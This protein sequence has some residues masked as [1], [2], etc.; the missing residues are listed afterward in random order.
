[1][2]NKFMQL[3]LVQAKTAKANNE[4]PVGAV[5]V[6]N[7]KVIANGYN[8]VETK[9]NSILHAEVIAI[10]KGIEALGTK[11]L[12]D[13]SLYVTKEPCI[14]CFGAITN[15]R[16]KDVYFGA[17]DIK[18]GATDY[19]LGLTHNNKINHYPNIY[20]GIMEF[21]CKSLLED[22]FRC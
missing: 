18:Y 4:V 15:A 1:M 3:A 17:Y 14:M 16:I 13:C 6:Y 10:S 12:S 9:S 22:F 2:K 20:G 5:L 19:I 7:N 11:Y 21:E 8:L